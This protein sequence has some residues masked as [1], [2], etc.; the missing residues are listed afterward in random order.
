MTLPISFNALAIE[1]PGAAVSLIKKTIE[2]L[3]KDEVLVRVDYASINKMDPMMAHRNLYQL[4]APYVLGFDFSGEVVQAGSE[5]G[6][7]AGDPVFGNAAMGGCFAEYLV[8]KKDRVL[9]RG[10]VPAKEASTFGIAFLT[11]YESLVITGDIMRHRG[12]TIYIAGAAGG[13][14]HF[15]V[16]IAKL[17]G[18]KVI[19][20]A[21]KAASLELLRRLQVDRVVDYSRQEVVAR[22]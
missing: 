11:A 16:Q 4:P 13:V 15:A 22:S 8:V 17:H 20:S 2:S 10:G 9:P 12:E 5:G 18:L 1:Q 3:G 21:G 6:F 19:G 14:G 7:K